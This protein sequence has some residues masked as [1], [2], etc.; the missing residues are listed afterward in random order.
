MKQRSVRG[1]YTA[2]TPPLASRSDSVSPGPKGATSIVGDR[3]IVS[4]STRPA[5]CSPLV[6]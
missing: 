5:W 6:R 4:F 2:S 1:L 3:V